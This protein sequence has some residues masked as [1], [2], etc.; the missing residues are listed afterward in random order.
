MFISITSDGSSM[1]LSW[2]SSNSDLRNT[3]FGLRPQ[4]WAETR[5]IIVCS[6]T[7]HFHLI[8]QCDGGLEPPESCCVSG[9][10][11]WTRG[12]S[13]GVVL[14]TARQALNVFWKSS[15]LMKRLPPPLFCR[16]NLETQ[17]CSADEGFVDGS[18]RTFSLGFGVSPLALLCW[19]A[20]RKS[21]IVQHM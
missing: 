3:T 14:C 20:S 6:Q 18:L 9:S 11:V 15:R 2:I 17:S 12:E 1:S 8:T 13:W 10:G 19:W 5:W 16:K 4:A 7:C 21:V